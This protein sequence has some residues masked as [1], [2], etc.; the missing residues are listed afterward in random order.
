M[1]I[2]SDVSGALL[3]S[4]PPIAA[5]QWVP[6]CRWMGIGLC[7]GPLQLRSGFLPVRGWVS[8]CVWAHCSCAVGSYLYMNGY[9]S[10]Y[11][12]SICVEDC[13]KETEEAEAQTAPPSGQDQPTELSLTCVARACSV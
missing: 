6:T 7:V 10:V 4:A 2:L 13:R 9:L 1:T 5:A 12:P 8:V 3:A 11:R